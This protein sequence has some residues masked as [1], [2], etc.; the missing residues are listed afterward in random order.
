MTYDT[1]PIA[2]I[3]GES[4]KKLKL[5]LTTKTMDWK[6]TDKERLRLSEKDRS[7]YDRAVIF[8][9][10][11]WAMGPYGG[12][13]RGQKLLISLGWAKNERTEGQRTIETM[14]KP[15]L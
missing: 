7:V 6:L 9:N 3:M 2:D 12:W 15:T 13:V 10:D 1:Q 14:V 11:D 5:L 4:I 8:M